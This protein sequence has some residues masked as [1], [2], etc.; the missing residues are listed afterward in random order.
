MFNLS[1]DFMW[2]GVRPDQ[3]NRGDI[4]MLDT[5]P[6]TL[7]DVTRVFMPPMLNTEVVVEYKSLFGKPEESMGFPSWFNY[8]YKTYVSPDTTTV[9]RLNMYE[10]QVYKTIT[11]LD[12]EIVIFSGQVFLM[13]KEE[14]DMIR[15][16]NALL[17]KADED[18]RLGEGK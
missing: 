8:R 15:Q 9:F 12:Y 14:S 7:Y 16:L 2:E 1:D 4:V 13:T 11:N 18:A 5:D 17:R 6:A 3:L 10:I